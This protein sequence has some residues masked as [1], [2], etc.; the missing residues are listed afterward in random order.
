MVA[1]NDANLNLVVSE[2]YEGVTFATL[3]QMNFLWPENSLFFQVSNNHFVA[4]MSTV[5]FLLVYV[6]A[7]HVFHVRYTAM[8]ACVFL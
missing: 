1:V 3:I 7:T 6:L 2:L 4:S 5:K 8:S